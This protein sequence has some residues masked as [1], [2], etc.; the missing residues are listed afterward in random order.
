[1]WQPELHESSRPVRTQP[2][3]VWN[4]IGAPEGPI[5]RPCSSMSTNTSTPKRMSILP[6]RPKSGSASGI[7]TKWFHVGSKGTGWSGRSQV[8]LEW[9]RLS[10]PFY[11]QVIAWRIS[12]SLQSIGVESCGTGQ[13]PLRSWCSGASERGRGIEPNTLTQTML[14]M[15]NQEGLGLPR[16][17]HLEHWPENDKSWVGSWMSDPWQYCDRLGSRIRRSS[18]GALLP[19]DM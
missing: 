11:C 8:T 2:N 4:A 5:H 9:R 18:W 17:N 13:L 7:S 10:L 12:W 15:Q 1:M 14:R 19:F 6:G 3:S 16:R